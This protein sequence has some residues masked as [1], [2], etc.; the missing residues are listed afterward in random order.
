M[1]L[2]VS[3]I[4]WDA[5]YDNEMYALLE[6]YRF[7]G[8]EIA[9]TRIFPEHPYER[10]REAESFSQWIYE[11]HGLV[12]SSMQS[13]LYGHSE[14]IFGSDNERTIL[15]DYML[16][17]VDFAA[18]TGCGN[19]VFGCPRNR[20]L[21]EGEDPDTAVEFF[22]GLAEYAASKNIAIG[23]EA[24]PVIYNTNFINDT[25]SAFEFIEKVRNYGVNASEGLTSDLVKNTDGVNVGKTVSGGLKVNLD[26]G[27]MIYNNED[28]DII[29]GKVHE[30]S[31]VHI[32]EPQLKPIEKRKIH[33]EIRDILTAEDYK[34]FISI[35]MGKG[36][37]IYTI[38]KTIDYINRIFR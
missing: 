27:T 4:A 1:K 18:V 12:I 21:M 8:L 3:N 19:L 28:A 14:R 38:E 31:H 23:F 9:P 22:S 24:N 5:G 25:A 35:E 15:Y 34:G 2:S 33:E 36:D 7:D 37:S 11:K 13:I 20:T 29:K 30:I 16:K 10:L 32:S 17:A 6:K 26:L